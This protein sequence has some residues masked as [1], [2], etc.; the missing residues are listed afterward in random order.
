MPD[1]YISVILL[2]QN[3]GEKLRAV[4]DGLF[5]SKIDAEFEV[6]AMDSTSLV[7]PEMAGTSMER[8]VQWT[9]DA[10]TEDQACY[11]S[12]VILDNLNLG[13]GESFQCQ[14]DQITT[15][16]V[17]IQSGSSMLL[18][19]CTQVIM[20]PG[21]YVVKGSELQVIKSTQNCLP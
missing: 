10:T 21:L 9:V 2:T 20:L 15:K 8:H 4:L 13:S 11:S 18:E 17:T 1:P 7:H 6:I 3:G 14:A 5:S 16:Q 19:Y 12:D